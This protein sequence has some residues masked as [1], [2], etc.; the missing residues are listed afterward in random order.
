MR[1]CH[2]LVR[3]FHDQQVQLVGAQ[4]TDM[5]ERRDTNRERLKKGLEKNGKSRPLGC[6]TQGSYAMHTMVQDAANDYDIDDGVYF[7]AD[8][9][10]GPRGAPMSSLDVRDMVCSALQDDRFSKAPEVRKHCVRVYY[11]E[12]FHVDVPAYRVTTVKDAWTGRE[13]KRYELASTSWRE[14]DPRA[15]TQWFRDAN[16]DLSPDQK[17]GGQFRRIVR[18]LKRFARSRDSWKS[19]TTSGFMLT[20]LASEVFVA[21]DGQD[22]VSLRETMKAIEARLQWNKVIEHPVLDENLSKDDDPRPEFLRSKL[23]ENLE[24]LRVLDESGCTHEQAM[25]AW[26]KVFN[27]DWFSKQPPPGEEEGGAK[28]PKK[29]V[30][31]AGGGRFARS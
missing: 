28:A 22:D 11:N 19:K 13:T 31:K 26:D 9:L 21:A 1:Q 16:K 2:S 14:S 6:H 7:T 30:E 4:R 10:N 18:L 25:S 8:D 23:A 20:K 24:H 12:G 5:R 3:L 15:V 29:A 17:G 27:T